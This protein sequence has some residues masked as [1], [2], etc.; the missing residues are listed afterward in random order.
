MVKNHEAECRKKGFTGRLRAH[1]RSQIAPGKYDLST[2]NYDPD[3]PDKLQSRKD[4]IE[5]VGF[6]LERRKGHSRHSH[7][8]DSKNYH[9]IISTQRP[10][11]REVVWKQ[12]NIEGSVAGADKPTP[13]IDFD[14]HLPIT[15]QKKQQ[16]IRECF[17]KYHSL[18]LTLHPDLRPAD[19]QI[20]L[21]AL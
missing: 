8:R 6:I 13:E 9:T 20:S 19:D 12:K 21:S 5:K 17:R 2:V 7:L 1:F 14:F 10:L 18:T 11:S 3:L 15:S 4:S 16:E